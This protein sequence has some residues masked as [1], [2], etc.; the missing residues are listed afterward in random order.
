MRQQVLSGGMCSP[1]SMGELH[2]RAHDFTPGFVLSGLGCLHGLQQLQTHSRVQRGVKHQ[3]PSLFIP[4][5]LRL[6][7]WISWTQKLRQRKEIGDNWKWG[8]TQHEFAQGRSCQ[9]NMVPFFYKIIDLFGQGRC[10][11]MQ[12]VC[13][14]K[15]K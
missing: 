14:K 8:E 1:C 4:P 11:Q 7:M 15:L 3:L 6:D 5:A 9:I 10:G 2:G 13:T 12:P